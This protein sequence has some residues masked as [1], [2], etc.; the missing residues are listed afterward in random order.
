[1]NEAP[2]PNARPAPTRRKGRGLWAD[3]ARR[4]LRNRL[5]MGCLAVV[6]VYAVLALLVTS[7]LLAD[8]WRQS[9]G[10]RYLAPLTSY[11]VIE[12]A[13]GPRKFAVEGSA[14]RTDGIYRYTRL[15]D[16]GGAGET[17]TIEATAVASVRG[18]TT[19]FGTDH[20]GQSILRKTV[21]GTKISL[22]VALF[23]AIISIV[24]GVPLGAAAGFFGKWF[25]EFVVWLY[26]TFTSIPGFLLILAFAFVL[27]DAEIAGYPLRGLPAVFLALGLTS[28]VGICR[29]IRGE[30][31]KH[32]ERD[33]VTAA[34]AYGASNSRLIFRH[35]LPNVTH[36]ILIDFSLRVVGFIQAEVILSFLGLGPT[37]QPSWGVM[38]NYARLELSRGVWWQLAAATVAVFGLALSLNIVGDA[39]RDAMDPKL[40]Q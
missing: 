35:I 29:L 25:D 15:K 26:T 38:I 40:K 3:A 23:A 24:I 21:F 7:G 31:I 8:D 30:V 34:R 37:E 12:L 28:W 11:E 27:R 10:P 14:E 22:S 20:L 6:G 16:S 17:K 4:F 18:R 32:R 9:V 2:T 36:L 19:L 39:L 1:M 5:A 13:G 33:Y